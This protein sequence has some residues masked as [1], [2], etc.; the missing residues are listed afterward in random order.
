MRRIIGTLLLGAVLASGC[1]QKPREPAVTR[2][3]IAFQEWVGDGLFYLARDKGFFREEGVEPVFIDEPLDSARRD[4]FKQGMLDMESGTIDQL[5]TKA[6]QNT[7]L[8]TLMVTDMSFGA[9]AIVAT[10]NIKELK[11]LAGKR[12]ALA[13][14]DVG[15]T[16]ISALFYQHKLPFN[17][18]VLV[19]RDPDEVATAFLKGEAD[20]CVTWEPQVS[21]ALERPGAHRLAT[22][23]DHPGII[24]DTLNVRKDFLEKDPKAVQGVMRGWFKALEYYK[25]H[26]EE[27]SGIIAGYYHMSAEEYRKQVEG[28]KWEN[29]AEQRS[30]LDPKEWAK[31]F[32]AIS[33]LKLAT[34]RISLRPEA[35]KF[36]DRTIMEK[37]YEDSK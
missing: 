37:L 33:S 7:P 3:S 10:G 21:Q 28:L 1:A 5:V 8:V 34:G 27:A 24:L 12:V 31:L 13:K 26:P 22:S 23:K 25:A 2:M 17:S 4:A 32:D 19:P 6:A 36:M 15:E 18:L 11:D 29:W 16:F 9:D 30:R 14:E 35:A 20:A